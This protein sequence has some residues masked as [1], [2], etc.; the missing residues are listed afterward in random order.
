MPNPAYYVEIIDTSGQSAMDDANNSV[1][2][3]L[4]AGSGAVV[5]TELMAAAALADA[6][7]ATPTT[8][9]V[10]AIPQL[11]NATTVDRQ[12]AV[13]AGLD[14]T[15]T[16]IAAAGMVG[17]LD[18]TSPSAVTENQF[19]AVRISSRRAV[20]GEG[21]I[22]HDA[23]VVGNPNLIAGVAQA[24]DD[25]APPNRVDTESDLTRFATDFD[26]AVFV[27]PH[28][29]QVWSYHENSSAA[30][31]DATVHAAPAAGLSLYV[32]TII[33][34]TGAA[35]AMNAFLEE[36]AATVLGPYYLEAT[37]GRGLVIQF[38]PPKKITPATALTIT[39]SAAIAHSIDITGFT[40]QG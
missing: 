35:T 20:L 17:Q 5:D 30:L 36:G 14:S 27:R 4:I 13:V 8:P 31:T 12:R 18:D 34:S 6:A 7:S 22:A 9:S 40:A 10:G 32:G 38:N 24:H 39:T 21:V 2:V 37:A 16:G 28:G 1:R 3:S 23:A 33:I 26:G 25:T 15:G 19:A 29:A 11:M